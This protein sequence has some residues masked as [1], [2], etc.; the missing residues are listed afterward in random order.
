MLLFFGSTNGKV[1]ETIKMEMG[2]FKLFLIE[3]ALSTRSSLELGNKLIRGFQ[4]M[5][6]FFLIIRSI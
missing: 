5:Y 4:K 3:S 2:N 6:L 1:N